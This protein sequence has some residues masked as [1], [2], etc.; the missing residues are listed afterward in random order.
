MSVEECSGF[1]LR[2]VSLLIN[3]SIYLL[4]EA[5][6]K[7][8]RLKE[9]EAAMADKDQ[10]LQLPAEERQTREQDY[11]RDQSIVRSDLQLA[12]ANVRMIQYSTTEIV[13][14]FLLP[15]MVERVASM[16]NYF[17]L[18][19][20][21]PKRK[22]LR[23]TNPEKYEFHPKKLLSQIVNIYANLAKHDTD[24]RFAEAVSADG[25]SYREEV[26]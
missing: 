23:V 1:Y 9:E 24:H 20:V 18:Q 19:L 4:D 16:L 13:K 12:N 3:D 11:Q 17:L 10:W 22:A 5:L 25:R 8:P 14:P 7:I 15:E 21:G 6:E 26:R 2:Y